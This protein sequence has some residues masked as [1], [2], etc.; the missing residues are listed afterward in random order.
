MLVINSRQQLNALA[1]GSV[2]AIGNYDGVHLGHQ[3]ILNNLRQQYPNRPLTVITFEPSPRE[4]FSPATAPPRLSRMADKLS[5]LKACGVDQVLVLPFDAELASMSA[6][7]FVQTILVTGL[8]IHALSVGEDY[9]YGE[10]RSGDIHSLATYDF[11]LLVQKNVLTSAHFKASV[12]DDA[13]DGAGA[14]HHIRISST[15]IRQH[16]LAGDFAS[17]ADLLGEPY[18][19][20]GEVIKGQQL[21]RTIGFPTLNLDLQGQL[22]PLSG[23]YAVTAMLMQ[24]SEFDPLASPQSVVIENSI[25][26]NTDATNATNAPQYYQGIANYGTRPSVDNGQPSLEVHLFDFSDDVYGQH[27]RVNFAAKIRDEQRF[28]DLAAL[29]Q[30]IQQDIIEAQALLA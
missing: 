22:P 26:N 17:A 14:N 29:Q 6:D 27:C 28:A 20:T 7:E 10:N 16:L 18:W 4:F 23:V 25:N 30:Q 15:L 2:A 8:Q 19:L 21:G 9:R 11:E 13:G 12:D 3:Q 24:S 1:T 5:R